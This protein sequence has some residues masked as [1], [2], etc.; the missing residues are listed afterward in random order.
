MPLP[1]ENKPIVI[2]KCGECN[3]CKDICQVGAIHGT[4]W[5]T[6]VH[7]DS[8]VDVYHCNGC[9]KCLANCPWT[10]KYIKNNS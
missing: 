3:V 9:L 1:A 7:R 8:I 5:K 6:Y 4:E 2:S 10:Q